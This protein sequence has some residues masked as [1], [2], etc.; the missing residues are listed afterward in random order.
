MI[1]TITGGT[2]SLGTAITKQQDILR[3][4][5]ITQIRV[6]SRDEQKQAKLEKEYKGTIELRTILGDVRSLDRMRLALRQSDYIIHAAALKMVERVEK[7]VPEAVRTNVEGTLNVQQ[8]VLENR[9]LCNA[10]LVSTDKAVDPINAYGCTKAMAEKTWLWGNQISATKFGICRYGNVFGSRG[11]VIELWHKKAMNKEYLPITDERMTRFFITVDKAAK[12]VLYHTLEDA[13]GIH[14]PDMKSIEM[15]RLAKIIWDYH[16]PGEKERIE[17]VGL[18]AGEK[19]HEVLTSHNEPDQI[20]SETAPRLTTQE[21]K[22]FYTQWII[23]YS[24]S[25]P[26]APWDLDTKPSLAFLESAMSV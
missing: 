8:A 15:V 25:G 14:I 22:E 18:R 9:T 5:D 2:G 4:Y 13:K 21:L 12:F 7:D 17:L 26:K 23:N 19:I 3:E 6:I 11:S 1:L 20:S 16:N 24:S 10:I